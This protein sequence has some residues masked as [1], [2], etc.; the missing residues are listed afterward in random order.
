MSPHLMKL[1]HILVAIIGYRMLFKM[2]KKN[3][4]T[5]NGE[6]TSPVTVKPSVHT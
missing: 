5:T 4:H 3:A 2:D 6:I 1:V